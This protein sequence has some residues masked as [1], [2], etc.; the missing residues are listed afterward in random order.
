[1][2]QALKRALPLLLLI[3]SP[4][5]A[6]AEYDTVA[7]T[8][9]R[10]SDTERVEE[11]IAPAAPSG[12]TKAY[13]LAADYVSGAKRGELRC[14]TEACRVESREEAPGR[15]HVEMFKRGESSFVCRFGYRPMGGGVRLRCHHMAPV[16]GQGQIGIRV[17]GR[18]VV[19]DWSPNSRQWHDTEWEIGQYLNGGENT[20]EI[21][22]AQAPK[23]YWFK[24][25]EIIGSADCLFRDAAP[26]PQ[27]GTDW[28]RLIGEARRALDDGRLFAE[29]GDHSRARDALNACLSKCQRITSS[30]APA[31]VA[32]QADEMAR[33]ARYQLQQLGGGSVPGG[34]DDEV[35]RRAYKFAYSSQGL[36][37]T[38]AAADNFA[39]RMANTMDVGG[40]DRWVAAYRFAYSSQGL[41]Y[42]S[43][44]AQRFAD[45]MMDADLHRFEELYRYAY[46]SQGL[47]LTK[48][49]ALRWAQEHMNTPPDYLEVFK[50]AY[51]YCYST[52]GCDLSKDAARDTAQEI[53]RYGRRGLEQFQKDYRYAYGP[54]GLDM[55]RSRALRYA[56]DNLR[57]L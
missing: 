41:D 12:Q 32:R 50:R 20:V 57:R 49:Q 31:D 36:N 19:W 3:A 17:N 29:K 39:R 43:A 15:H 35:F 21:R 6:F 46:S 30:G 44:E 9:D 56:M 26:G 23:M 25:V 47:D 42:N 18:E 11:C 5:L 34:Y 52:Q 40:F 4:S 8:A 1:M 38:E 48:A 14:K 16:P 55:S 24:R 28:R 51:Q 22:L 53:A 2:I 10:A 33:Q 7:G 54:G 13:S 27:P 37:M 45:R